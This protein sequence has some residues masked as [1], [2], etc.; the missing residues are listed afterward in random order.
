MPH[1]AIIG[2]TTSGKSTLAK[3]LCEE[4]NRAGIATL[5]LIKP[6]EPY[7]AK[8]Q[9]SDADKFLKKFWESRGCAVFLE[10]ADAAVEKSDTRFHEVFSRGRHNGHRCFYVSQRHAQVHPCIR[11][12]CEH[13]YLFRVSNNSAKIWAEEFADDGIYQAT[14]AQRYHFVQCGRYAPAKLM[15]PVK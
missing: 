10:M 13:L 11:E 12:N 4:F 14:T 1:A 3:R 5:A 7:P 8:W 2:M 9:T 15:P 6:N